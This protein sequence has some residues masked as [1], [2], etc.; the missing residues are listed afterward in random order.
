MNSPEVRIECADEAKFRVVEEVAKTLARSYPVVTI[1]GVRARIGSGWGLLRASNTQPVLVLRFEAG[2][3][4][5]L[6]RITAIF[7]AEL[8]RFPE[9][10]WEEASHG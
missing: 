3:Q 1:D 7:R 9:V 6:D 5:E 2:S 4:G 10:R 8:S